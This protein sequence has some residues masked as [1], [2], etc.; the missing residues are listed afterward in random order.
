METTM[1]T[2]KAFLDKAHKTGATECDTAE[3]HLA[4]AK[5]M[6]RPKTREEKDELRDIIR[7]LEQIHTVCSIP[8]KITDDDTSLGV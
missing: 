4:L 3:K 6:L 1:N 7:E 8:S 5:A 2:L